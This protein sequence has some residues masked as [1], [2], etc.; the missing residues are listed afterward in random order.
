MPSA[1]AIAKRLMLKL[2]SE[3]EKEY[4]ESRNEEAKKLYHEIASIVHK[5]S[6]SVETVL[7]VLELV[8]HQ[9]VRDRLGSLLDP[10]A[11]ADLSGVESDSS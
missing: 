7:Y 8:R 11:E 1:D 6:P 10:G 3:M 9:V 4:R 2:S 5:M